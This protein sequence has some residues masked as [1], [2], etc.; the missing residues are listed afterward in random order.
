MKRSSTTAGVGL[1]A[2]ARPGRVGHMTALCITFLTA[3]AIP[4]RDIAPPDQPG[5]FHVGVTVFPAVMSGGRVTQIRAWYP[6][7]EAADV[8]TRY[9]IFRAG[10]SYQLKSPLRAVEG[11]TALPG[12][13]PPV[14][15]DHG[16]PP[17]GTDPRS[18]ANLPLH[19]TMAS[20]AMPKLA[21]INR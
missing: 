19:E 8:Q 15:H 9:T 11:A 16:G 18:V 12:S 17:A 7:L 10:G 1:A 3:G 21:N 13:F 20:H 6:T 5:P 2:I 14:V 4:A